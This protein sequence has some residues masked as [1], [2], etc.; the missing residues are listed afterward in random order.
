[1]RYPL[2]IANM[3]CIYAILALSL[4]LL[5]GY[6]GLPS[7]CHAAFF[8]IGAYIY[9]LTTLGTGTPFFGAAA[10][11]IV[12]AVLLSFFISLPSLRL[13]G[14]Y[15]VLASLAFQTII[16]SVL[17]N[18]VELTQGP[19]GIP[20][21]PSPSILTFRLDTPARY[22]LLSV[23][24]T[25]ASAV[26]LHWLGRSPFGRVLKAI[27]EDEIA[28]VS[29]G[30][31]TKVFKIV[32]FAIAGGFAGLAGAIF[33]GYI[34]YI[35]PTSFTLTESVF[36][37]SLVIVGGSGNT[38]GPII[39]TFILLLLPEVLRSIGIPDSIAP[40]LRLIIYSVLIVLVMRF[41]PQGLAG[42]YR[43]Q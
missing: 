28:V 21:I 5:V 27:R 43:Y 12:G 6:T 33:A 14:D 2:H 15:F 23:A 41:R 1:M 31:N 13:S 4:N 36:I 25:V 35:D 7:L 10:V 22:L 16:F 38:L 39:G 11:S 29:L 19:F 34:G 42:E 8:G 20:D 30:K 9:T 18:W 37:I 26:L 3:M 24:V 17:H 40:N 32:A